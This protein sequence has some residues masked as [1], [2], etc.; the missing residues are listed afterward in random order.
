MHSFRNACRFRFQHFLRAIWARSQKL[1]SN[2]LFAFEHLS[3]K[4]KRVVDVHSNGI[5]VQIGRK[6]I[7]LCFCCLLHGN[8]VEYDLSTL[9]NPS[10]F[11]DKF[12]WYSTL[13]FSDFFFAVTIYFRTNC[14]WKCHFRLSYRKSLPMVRWYY[15][16][17]HTKISQI[18]C[19][20]CILSEIRK[21]L[22]YI[23]RWIL[24]I[25]ETWK[26]IFFNKK[27]LR[28]KQRDITESRQLLLILKNPSV[29]DRRSIHSSEHEFCPKVVT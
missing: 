27:S 6:F 4:C 17:S 28:R 21:Y 12:T 15:P 16:L 11:L 20:E 24:P 1:K 19:H 22:Y 5:I 25:L 14:T 2:R 26:L 9:T 13:H 18:F 29:F 10:F 3:T 7:L 8:G 23:F